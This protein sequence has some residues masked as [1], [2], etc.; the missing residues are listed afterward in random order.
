MS[1]LI[2]SSRTTENSSMRARTAAGIR[3]SAPAKSAA[4]GAPGRLASQALIDP[5]SLV[6]HFLARIAVNAAVAA[7][8][9]PDCGYS[10]EGDDAI[11]YVVNEAWDDVARTVFTDPDPHDPAA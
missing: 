8:A 9:C 2:G 1:S 7:S 3:Q 5:A 6:P 11:L 10:T 4:E